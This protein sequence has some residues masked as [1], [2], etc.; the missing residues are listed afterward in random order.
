MALLGSRAL[1]KE[2]AA[3]PWRT[4]ADVETFI[5]AAKALAASD[6]ARLVPLILPS[7]PEPSDVT[8]R[9]VNCFLAITK[10]VSDPKLV[11][12]LLKACRDPS[13]RRSFAELLARCVDK[14]SQASVAALLRDPDPGIRHF[15]AVVLRAVGSGST[16][17][18]LAP[19]LRVEG[20]S[21]VEAMQLAADLG[22]SAA[23]DLIAPLVAEGSRLER[24]AAVRI[25]GTEPF[26]RSKAAAAGEVV[27]SGLLDPEPT[28]IVQTIRSLAALLPEDV[29]FDRLGE[30]LSNDDDAA[31]QLAA[32]HGISVHPSPR[33]VELL[34]V[35]QAGGSGAVRE[36]VA[37]ALAHHDG[38]DAL[39]V[40]ERCLADPL[41]AVRNAALEVVIDKG[42]AGSVELGR[43]MLWLLRSPDIHVKRQA[44]EIAA[45]IGDP[46]GSLWP[47]LLQ[48]L[49]DEDWWVRERVVETLVEV[50]GADL[51]RYVVAYLDDESDVLR[52]YAIEVLMRIKDPRSV[53]AVVRVARDDSDWWV[54]ER[55]IECLGELGD[56]RVVPHIVAL[57]YSDPDLVSVAV[58]ALKK[59]GPD[60]ESVRFLAEAI[61]SETAEIRLAAIGAMRDVGENDD[62]IHL[63]DALHDQDHRVRQA[64]EGLMTAWTGGPQN[65]S[66]EMAAHLTGLEQL[67]WRMSEAGADDLFILSDRPPYMKHMGEMVP[68][69]EKA[70][71]AAVVETTLRGLLTPVQ[72]ESIENGRDV[73]YSMA[74][75]SQGLRFRVN[76]LRD[77]KGWSAVFRRIEDKPRSFEELGLPDSV[78]AL[79]DLS[80]GLVLVG[81]ATGSG[82]S[83][84]VAAMI[85]HLNETRRKHI[86]TIED[87][88]ET[89]HKANLCQVTQREVGSHTQSF[90]GAL[91]STLR[92][93]PDVIFVGE[94]RD[95]ETVSFAVTAAE[96]GHL[97]FG[98]IH[99]VDGEAGIDRL[100]DMFPMKRREQ[101]RAMVSQTL[102]AIVCQQL[103]RGRNGDRVPALEILLNNEAV[104]THIRQGQGHQIRS[105]LSISRSLGMQS[106]DYAL[107]RLV[108]E[109]DVTFD[110]A[111]PRAVRKL[112]FESLLRDLQRPPGSA[113]GNVSRRSS[114]AAAV[115]DAAAAVPWE[116]RRG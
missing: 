105:V 113:G 106:M 46:D 69:Q 87:P 33:T 55:A 101:V 74:V 80:D 62:Q 66:G 22:G 63:E 31:L 43:M 30:L 85:R 88:I 37:Q 18:A 41:L 72:V 84:T 50:A 94:M 116:D 14:R 58:E 67:L 44:V 112:E 91:R 12:P 53:G 7:S 35:V 40:L 70:L 34:G 4:S 79:C 9:R 86:I 51:T 59:L 13:L 32:V 95:L 56:K 39:T 16:I 115:E 81:G 104:S 10:D 65:R 49:R 64:A 24:L 47:R 48:M 68:L 42:R 38:P 21:R 102:R 8:R 96:T 97:V 71:P 100:I 28:V 20:E 89:V 109:G 107:A 61:R 3:A 23:L 108:Y 111:F 2:F 103:L 78:R 57:A 73:D 93:D 54:R 11:A 77:L 92:E 82:K 45:E 99:T 52:R 27:L 19:V 90:H 60:P 5:R 15:G 75:P 114:P 6:L 26:V 110:E 36:A 25:L 1:Q 17:Q 29:L 83:S 76:V 98:T